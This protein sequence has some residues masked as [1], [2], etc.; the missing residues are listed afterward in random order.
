MLH[1]LLT[2]G[3]I[4]PDSLSSTDAPEVIIRKAGE[5]V[6]HVCDIERGQV[7]DYANRRVNLCKRANIRISSTNSTLIVSDG[8]HENHFIE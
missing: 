7:I 6:L 8:W 3:T 5:S 1:R 4:S 2:D